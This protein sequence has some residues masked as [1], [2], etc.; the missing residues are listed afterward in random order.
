MYEPTVQEIKKHY[1]AAM[2]SVKTIFELRKKENITGKDSE[3]ILRNQEH[4]LIMLNKEY[5]DN[6]DLGP[7]SDAIELFK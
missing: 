7:F 4:L 2:D 6:E 5:W 3:V 1:S